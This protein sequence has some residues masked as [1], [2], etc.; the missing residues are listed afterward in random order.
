MLGL[1]AIEGA[2][3]PGKPRWLATLTPAGRL[4]AHRIA[5]QRLTLLTEL[6]DGDRSE[7]HQS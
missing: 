5:K 4:R 2:S 6:E 7:G 3:E 1:I